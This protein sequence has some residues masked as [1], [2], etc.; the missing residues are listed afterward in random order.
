[1]REK[2]LAG[3]LC[4]RFG[5][6]MELVRFCNS[7][8]E[9]NMMAVAAAV[10]WSGKGR[11]K[12]LVF[13]NGYHGATL[14][15]RGAA[16][17]ST[18][19]GKGGEGGGKRDVNLPHEWVVAPYNDV[20]AT[21]EALA[22]L[23]KDSLAAVLVEPMLGSGGGVPGSKVFL[24]FLR[25]YATENGALLI[26]DE[27]M[28]SRLGY[29]GLGYEVGIRPDLM[30]LGKWV[31]GG[32]SFGAFGGRRD[33]MGMF[34]P[35]DGCLAHAG[36]FNNNVISMAAGVAGCKMLNEERLGR[37]NGMGEDMKAKMQDVMDRHLGEQKANG[38]AQ[39]NGDDGTQGALETPAKPSMKDLSNGHS[40]RPT[41][42]TSSKPASP[43][44]WISGLGSILVIHFAPSPL[45]STF[46]SL[47]F[48]YMLTQN[49]YLGER[50]FIALSKEIKREHVDAFVDATER[51]I[52]RYKEMILGADK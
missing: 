24:Q 42:G 15:F 2:E 10:A 19:T 28:T 3:L 38:L 8:T 32:M 21:K 41:E 45:Q 14:S 47:F 13:G 27:V 6:A 17:T 22:A 29:R 1:M 31:G 36:T 18:G 44:T 43:P 52:V 11:K 16:A 50:G 35:R 39:T 34:D 23:P 40:L 9:A 48:H 26:F 12:V 46:Q 5:H 51:F 7:G 4:E 33:I 30:T 20:E 49:I 37:V 25:N